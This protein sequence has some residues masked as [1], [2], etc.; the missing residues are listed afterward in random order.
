VPPILVR[1]GFLAVLT[2]VITCS[3]NGE[4]RRNPKDGLIY[5]WIPPGTY[6]MGC[7]ADSEC[8]DWEISPKPVQIEKGYWMGQT[9]VT[10][11]AYVLVMKTN[12]SR[13]RGVDLPVDQVSWFNARKYCQ[14]VGMRLPSEAEW[15]YGA[16]GGT[17]GPRY[18]SLASIGW[19]DGNSD[20][21]THPVAQKKPNAF[22][23]YDMLGNM[24]EWVE[25][26]YGPDRQKRVLRGGSFYNV[27]RDL[28]AS[29]RLW[30]TPE[31]AHRDM[32]VRCVGD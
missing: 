8:F 3:C 23:L 17:S 10:Q 24:W 11:R 12:P 26:A 19:Y 9:E 29:S 21:R 14:A 1:Y 5:V 6:A 20:D 18:D 28:R 4:T 16:R 15:E 31:T 25:D 27:A 2:G 13:Y 32:G 7:S 30:A 22:G